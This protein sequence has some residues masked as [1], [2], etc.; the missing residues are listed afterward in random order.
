MTKQLSQLIGML[1]V[2]GILIAGIIWFMP[3]IPAHAQIDIE[4]EAEPI[5]K[6]TDVPTQ[7]GIEVEI[8]PTP[9][10]IEPRPSI[11]EVSVPEMVPR[12]RPILFTALLTNDEGRAQP[13]KPLEIWIDGEQIRRIRTDDNGAFGLAL[14]LDLEPGEHSYEVVYAG[15][16][17]YL[18]T[19]TAGTF[20]VRALWLTIESVPPLAGIRYAIENNLYI[21]ED[22]GLVHIP[23]NEP[24]TYDLQ[25]LFLPADQPT[26]DTKISFERWGDAVF[27]P[28]R[29]ITVRDDTYLQAGFALEHRVAQTFID[30]AGN[31]VA[32]ERISNLTL[33]TSNG[34]THPYVN[35]KPRWLQANRIARR[36]NGLEVAPIS[37]AVYSVMMEG[38]NVV[39][40]SQQRFEVTPEATWVI[41]LLLYDLQLQAHDAFFGNSVG[42]GAIL[43]YPNERTQRL[44]FDENGKVLVTSLPR[45]LYGVQITGVRGMAPLTPVKL[46]KNQDLSLK[47]LSYAD[48]GLVGG[49]GAIV[50]IGLLFFGRPQLL[51]AIRSTIPRPVRKAR[52]AGFFLLLFALFCWFGYQQFLDSAVVTTENVS[53]IQAPE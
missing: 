24:G 14:R 3:A 34:A 52:Y 45:G 27:S 48:M 30:L 51:G 25:I 36:K 47:V 38:S 44:E 37:Y 1:F 21:S 49:I 11:L 53:S 41:K 42:K 22:D 13:N 18:G 43:I 16:Q 35:G 12:S 7:T 19:V 9:S 15:T 39:N 26:N 4:P 10:S 46:S 31:S 28:N 6:P 20:Q 40:E 32:P 8:E 23:L 33:R 17:A 50:A 5:V 29:Q 2:G